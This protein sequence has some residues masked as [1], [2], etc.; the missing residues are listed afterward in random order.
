MKID[1]GDVCG[2][3]EAIAW[4]REL[5]L[6][7][8]IIETHS[9]RVKDAN[10]NEGLD[11]TPFGDCISAGKSLLSFCPIFVIHWVSRN[12]NVMAHSLARDARHFESPYYWTE[13]PMLVEGLPC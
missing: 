2:V 11:V 6:Q 5:D 12:V 9:K 13:P 8:V 3:M 4:A 7:S 1:E 10:T